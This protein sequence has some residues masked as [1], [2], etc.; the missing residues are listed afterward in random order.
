MQ[1]YQFRLVKNTIA[2]R[3]GLLYSV[4]GMKKAAATKK[5]TTPPASDQKNELDGLGY[6]G[7]SLLDIGWRLLFVVL[8]FLLGGRELDKY[9]GTDPWFGVIGFL[10]IIASFVLIVRR[11]LRRIPKEYGGLKK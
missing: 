5:T 7:V 2:T 3:G 8:F 9:F 4:A 6:F 11:T 10:L 1:N